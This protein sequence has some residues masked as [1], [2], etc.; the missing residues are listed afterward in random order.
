[1]SRITPE[2]RIFFRTLAVI[3]AVGFA[4]TMYY[5]ISFFLESAK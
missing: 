2:A 4:L 1:M 5:V 3:Y